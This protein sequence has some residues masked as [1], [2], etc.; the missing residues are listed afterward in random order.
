MKREK[1]ISI[2]RNM[3]NRYEQDSVTYRGD[4]AVG[5]LLLLLWVIMAIN[6]WF[7]AFY[8]PQ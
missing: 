6:F 4:L 8:Y 2:L 1:M 5:Y 7:F 3:A